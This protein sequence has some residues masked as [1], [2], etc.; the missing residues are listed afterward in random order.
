M[1]AQEFYTILTKAGFQYEAECKANGKPIKLVKMS[2]GDGNGASYN[3]V[4]TQTALKRKVW[5]GNLNNLYQDKVNTAWLVVE[6]VIPET[7][8][9]WWVREVGVW[10]D[11]GVLYAIGKYPESY[12]PLINNGAGREVSIR[13]IFTTTNADNVTLMLD[14]SVIQATR[15]WV[16]DFVDAE[17]AS[18]LS[19]EHEAGKTHKYPLA[20]FIETDWVSESSQSEYLAE[21]FRTFGQSGVLG[22][23]Q[24][25]S[26]GTES[27]N[28]T[29]DGAY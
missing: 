7:V 6:A 3:P 22:S 26:A 10:T 8:G 28:R 4:D 21:I 15:A 11:T 29:F 2:V 13:T 14:G 27:F 20:N 18:V 23:R 1:A 24:Y 12:K 16:K 5:E 9:G 17:L 25:G 19:A